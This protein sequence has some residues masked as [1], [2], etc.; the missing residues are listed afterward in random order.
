MNAILT[1]DAEED[2]LPLACG[3]PLPRGGNGML[4]LNGG[5]GGILVEVN[6]GPIWLD[7][8]GR[9][10]VRRDSRLLVISRRVDS[11]PVLPVNGKG[12]V[13]GIGWVLGHGL[14]VTIWRG[15]AQ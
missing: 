7:A 3:H 10:Q 11:R 13:G 12:D 15:T 4:L 5:N 6:A 2:I 9:L 1:E 14:R 8:K